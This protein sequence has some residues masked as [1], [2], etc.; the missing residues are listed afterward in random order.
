MTLYRTLK[1]NA[2]WTT[3]TPPDGAQNILLVASSLLP[4]LV[5]DLHRGFRAW[6]DAGFSPGAIEPA[7]VF[8]TAQ[9]ALAFAFPESGP[10]EVTRPQPLQANVG[11]ARD[12]AGW[13]LLLDKWMET[14]VVLARARHVWTPAELASALPYLAPIYQPA[15]LIEMSPVNWER[16]ARALA[17]SIVDGALKGD[18]ESKGPENKHWKKQTPAETL[19]EPSIV[20]PVEPSDNSPEKPAAKRKR[21]PRKRKEGGSTA[22]TPS[23][24]E[25]EG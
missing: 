8:L 22:A 1:K 18:G 24:G 11:A 5:T 12:L 17:Q 20:S 21:A 15:S 25:Q 10:P 19:A 6:G 4:P 14:F 13:L 3:S 7:R 23:D 16:M 9:G 2:V